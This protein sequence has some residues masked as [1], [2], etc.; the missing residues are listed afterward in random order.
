MITPDPTVFPS[1]I[2]NTLAD[3]LQKID[4]DLTIKK[5]PL[6]S[7]DP[8]QC[9]GITAAL[10]SPD[11]QSWEMGSQNYVGPTLNRY[12]VGIQVFAQDMDQER[13]LATISTLSHAV[14]SRLSSDMDMR[15]ALALLENTTN[16][17]TEKFRRSGIPTQR[18]LSN[19]IEGSFLFMS[20]LE[21]F[22]ET[23]IQ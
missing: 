19:E 14:R 23:E 9:L 2:V 21:F 3:E 13:G 6:Q 11:E 15:V 1:N 4:S 10:W 18:F 12:T 20:N 22:V 16:G 8:V 7:G 5:R 17:V